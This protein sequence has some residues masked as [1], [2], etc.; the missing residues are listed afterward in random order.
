[1]DLRIETATLFAECA[2]IIAGA[3]CAGLGEAHSIGWLFHLGVD[4]RLRRVRPVGS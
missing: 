2:I 4:P 1:M 3:T